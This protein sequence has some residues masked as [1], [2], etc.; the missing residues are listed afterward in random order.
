M[1]TGHEATDE[2]L[3]KY[4]SDNYT[5]AVLYEG[6]LKLSRKD[7]GITEDTAVEA[8]K[9]GKVEETKDLGE[10]EGNENMKLQQQLLRVSLQNERVIDEDKEQQ[11]GKKVQEVQTKEEESMPIVDNEEKPSTMVILCTLNE[12]K[13]SSTTNATFMVE[14]RQEAFD[15]LNELSLAVTNQ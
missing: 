3:F 11:E 4:L 14:T 13:S 10:K 9:E 6:E 5:P 7:V 2:H 15:L 12:Q 1:L 8:E